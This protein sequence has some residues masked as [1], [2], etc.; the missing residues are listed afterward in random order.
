MPLRRLP[1]GVLPHDVY[2]MVPV[3]FKNCKWSANSCQWTGSAYTS[4]AVVPRDSFKVT[5]GIIS[6]SC[7]SP[8]SVRPLPAPVLHTGT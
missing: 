2:S 4:N 3:Y 1:K 6:R 5:K 7:L 8:T